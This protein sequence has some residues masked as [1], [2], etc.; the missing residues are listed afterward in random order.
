MKEQWIALLGRCDKPT[1]AVEDYCRYLSGALSAHG[2]DLTLERVEWNAAGWPAALRE[3]RQRV[4]LWQGQWVLVQ[5]TALAWSARGFP[6]RFVQLLRVLTGA[7]ARV[8]VVFHDVEPYSGERVIDKLRRRVQVHA[9]RNTLELAEVAIFTVPPEKI[10]WKPGQLSRVSFI[11][12]GANLPLPSQLEPRPAADTTKALTVAVFGITGG[13]TGE[14]E[15]REIVSAARHAAS[16]LGGF[17]LAVF[18]RHAEEREAALRDALRDVPVEVSVEGVLDGREVVE[19]L[20]GSDVLLFVRGGISTRRSSAIAG[21]GCGLP[22]IARAGSET[23]AP[24][25]EAGVAFY[26]EAEGNDLGTVLARVLES[27]D[28]RT[29]LAENSRRAYNEHFAWSAIAK[30][31]VEA[32]RLA[33]SDKELR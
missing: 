11:P 26:S 32:L 23:A 6:R 8:G 33:A 24:I 29:M 4:R 21:I 31:Y 25:T 3:L 5:Y 7:G 20:R 14:R 27:A 22:V 1:D 30:K 9:M 15:R 28:Y 13:A 2:I 16:R 19:K 17:R 12:V 18:G 10:S